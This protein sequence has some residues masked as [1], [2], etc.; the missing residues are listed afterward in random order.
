MRMNRPL[1]NLLLISMAAVTISIVAPEVSTALEPSDFALRAPV[2]GDRT[3]YVFFD[4]PP[5]V[6]DESKRDLS[7]IR[8]FSAGGK[9][10][11]YIIWNRTGY[12][13]SE[14]LS[15]EVLNKSYIPNERSTFTLDLGGEYFK[16]NRLKILTSS[17]DFAR[18]VTIE[19]SPD[20]RNF[21]TIK[22]DAYIFDFT[23]EHG[24]SGTEISYPTTDYRYLKVTIWDDGEEP[25]EN[26]GGEISIVE[27]TK[28]ETTTLKSV[29]KEE[30]QNKDDM[31]TEIV[32][33]LKYRNIPSDTIILE[34]ENENFSR[35]LHI[36]AGNADDPYEYDEVWNDHIYSIRT[37]KFARKRLTIEYPEVQG[38]YLKLI[39]ENRDDAPLNIKSIEVKGTP[40]KVT[41]LA[42]PGVSYYL[43]FKNRSANAPYYDIEDTFSYVDTESISRWTL[44]NVDDNPDYIPTTH[45]VPFSERHPWILWGT[46]VFMVVVLGGIIIRLMMNLSRE[47]EGE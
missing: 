27:E 7:D 13:S 8:V 22:N 11:P 18:I 35:D 47:G 5:A 14:T 20:N 45:D 42:E 46:I 40:K 15:A 16:T 32:I 28:G 34:V 17:I 30:G 3:G 37:T 12:W 4:I 23:T 41:F 9:E 36:L 25:L 39:I 26:L 33:D 19:G 10:T 31:T 21:V 38:R 43:Y 6:Y 29:I 2:Q 24:A 1:I 44:G